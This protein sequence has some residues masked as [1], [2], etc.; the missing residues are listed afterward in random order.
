MFAHL[1]LKHGQNIYKPQ[2]VHWFADCS[3]EKQLNPSGAGRDM[4][5]FQWNYPAVT[6]LANTVWQRLRKGLRF[7]LTVFMYF[8]NYKEG[9]RGESSCICHE[10]LAI[11]H[12]VNK[13]TAGHPSFLPLFALSCE[14]RMLLCTVLTSPLPSSPLFFLQAKHFLTAVMQHPVKEFLDSCYPPLTKSK[15]NVS[16]TAL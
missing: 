8:M 16:I 2:I 5:K 4:N 1:N 15:V 7:F 3:I 6:S 10:T 13:T 12:S 11:P 9:H 14:V